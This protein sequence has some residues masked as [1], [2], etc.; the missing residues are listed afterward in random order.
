MTA[1]RTQRGLGALAAVVVLVMLSLMA[2]TIV[3]LGTGQQTVLAQDLLAER[4]AQA[5][6]AGIEWGLHQAF[7]GPWATCA[8]VS[9]TLDL[10]ADTGMRVTVSCSSTLY[11][12]GEQSPGTAQTVRVY[13][14]D[15]VACS[16]SSCPDATAAA[17]PGYVERR[18]QVHATQ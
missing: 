1:R 5:A 8:G 13:T 18:R 11:N 15:A 7:K 4:A 6:R 2:A 17:Q 10:T 3:R 14:L 16:A 12:E 9:Q